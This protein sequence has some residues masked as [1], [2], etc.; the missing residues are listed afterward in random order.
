MS[1]GELERAEFLAGPSGPLWYRGYF[2]D[3]AGHTQATTGDIQRIKE[4]FGVSRILVGHTR[5]PTI[6]PLYAGDVIAVQVYPQRE[7][8]GVTHF[9][10]LLVRDGRFSR[11]K[12]D[13]QIEELFTQAH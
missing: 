12:P 2:A 13:G 9:E 7:P 3:E 11:A 4:H 10:A 5:V 8:S 6:T 1:G